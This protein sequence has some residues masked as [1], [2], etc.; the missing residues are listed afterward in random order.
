MKFDCYGEKKKNISLVW[1]CLNHSLHAMKRGNFI[2][3]DLM[4]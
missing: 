1:T 2:L 4:V 3:V